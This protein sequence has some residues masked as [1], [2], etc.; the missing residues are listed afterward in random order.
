MAGHESRFQLLKR[1]SRKISYFLVSRA[2][3]RDPQREKEILKVLFLI[4]LQLPRGM[5]SPYFSAGIK[6]QYPFYFG[7][8]R[9][10]EAR[11]KESFYSL[12]L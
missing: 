4:F 6:I 9:G 1:I 2:T 12:F 7:R 3:D 8:K 10:R 11:M 5:K